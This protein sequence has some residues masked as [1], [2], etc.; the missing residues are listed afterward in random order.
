[1]AHPPLEAQHISAQ[2]R[3]NKAKEIEYALTDQFL[4]KWYPL[5][6]DKEKG[7]FYTNFTHDWKIPKEQDK[8]IITQARHTWTNAKAAQ[9]Y[10]TVVHFKEGAK[11]GFNFLKNAL[12]DSQ[13][14]GFY[15]TVTRDGKPKNISDLKTAYGNAFG[16]YALATYYRQSGDTAA[17]NLA[18]KAFHWLEK[19]SHDPERKGYFQ[20]LKRDGKPIVKPEKGVADKTLAYKDQNSSIHL[21][22]AFTELYSVWPDSLLRKRL[23]EMLLLVRDTIITD[24]GYLTLYFTLDW[25]PISYRDSTAAVRK[26]NHKY[27]HVSFGHDVETAYLMLEAAH[28]LGMESDTVTMRIA[29]KMVDHS[30]NNGWDKEKGGFYEQGYY[31]KGEGKPKIIDDRKN[32]WAQAEGLN[33]LLLM[34]EL[35]PNDN[36]QY[37]DKYNKQWQYIKQYLIDPAYGGWYEW[38]LDKTPSSKTEYKGHAW[39]A[40][41]H[42]GRS[43]MNILQRLRS[44]P[45]ASEQN[46]E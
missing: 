43:L 19:N 41:Y 12:W 44:D 21:L 6:I 13:Y 37:L 15:A 30:L 45:T 32:W 42:D 3:Q 14:G 10:P 7:G 17:L 8:A 9:L 28:A 26:K 36:M 24:K 40:S 27:D 34:A 23:S 29:K 31:L 25:Q 38:G 46:K 4:H 2:E 35:Y 5:A 16:I 39:K 22:E 33:T 1:M 11:Q 20:H 18:K